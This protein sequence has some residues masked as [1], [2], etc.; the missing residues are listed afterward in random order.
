MYVWDGFSNLPLS[1]IIEIL[2]SQFETLTS[3]ALFFAS[4]NLFNQFGKENVSGIYQVALSFFDK[5]SYSIYLTH[6][7][8]IWNDKLNFMYLSSSKLLNFVLTI[9]EVLIIGFC[10]QNIYDKIAGMIAKKILK[11]KTN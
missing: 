2:Q 3:A 10:F 6:A 11:E 1:S 7:Y 5:Y 4:Y 8:F 9:A